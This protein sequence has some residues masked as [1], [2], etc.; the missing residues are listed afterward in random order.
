MKRRQNSQTISW[1]TDIYKRDLLNLNPEYQRRSVWNQ[2]YKD[3]FIDTILLEYPSPP[4]FLYEDIDRNGVAR[5]DLV[6][7]KQRLTAVFEFIDDRFPVSDE[8]K[9]KK[10]SWQIFFSVG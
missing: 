3:Y 7:G 4:I 10:I 2:E 9:I 6:D 1:F 8:A 5:Y